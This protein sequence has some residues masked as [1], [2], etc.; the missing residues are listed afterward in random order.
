ME[1]K[2]L[3]QSKQFTW[4]GHEYFLKYNPART[5]WPKRLASTQDALR[6]LSYLP[7]TPVT[8][9]KVVERAI[10][11]IFAF[12]LHATLPPISNMKALAS[13]VRAAVWGVN[14]KRY[15]SW[16]LAC[17]V[18]YRAHMTDVKSALWYSHVMQMARGFCSQSNRDAYQQL[19]DTPARL[20]PRG[21]A[22]I[23]DSILNSLGATLTQDHTFD[24]GPLGQARHSELKKLGHLVRDA[25]R[26]QLFNSVSTKRKNV[27]V[28]DYQVDLVVSS[29]YYRSKVVKFRA[30]LVA[31]LCD[32]VLTQERIA[33]MHE[34]NTTVCTFCGAP[35]EDIE[36]VLWT[37]PRWEVFR[38]LGPDVVRGIRSLPPAA[39]RCSYAL[40]GMTEQLVKAWPK[41]QE[42]ASQIVECHQKLV[43]GDQKVGQPMQ[44][45]RAQIA[46]D[47]LPAIPDAAT[48]ANGVLLSVSHVQELATQSHAWMYSRVQW[49]Q[50]MHW[51]T[52]LK[53]SLQPQAVPR[54]SVIEL[55]VSYIIASGGAR[56]SSGLSEA[57]HG[58]WWTTQLAQF[59]RALRAMQ[60]HV[61]PVPVVPLQDSDAPR[62]DW[63][64]RWHIPPQVACVPGLMVPGHRSVRDYL[65]AWSVMPTPSEATATP[66]AELW[67]RQPIGDHESQ[68][69]HYSMLP[70]QS[71]AWQWPSSVPRIRLRWKSRLPPWAHAFYANQSWVREVKSLQELHPELSRL[72]Q[73]ASVEGTTG[74]GDLSRIAG[75]RTKRSLL[76][77]SLVSHNLTAIDSS[78]HIAFDGG[79]RV[80]CSL[81]EAAAPLSH[82]RIWFTKTCS[83]DRG[84]RRDLV[85]VANRRLNDLISICEEDAATLKAAAALLP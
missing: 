4:L 37:C 12:G 39:R 1:W 74:R 59:M 82:T 34:G 72:V 57:S 49:N 20:R 54:I 61:L 3:A 81:C 52:S 47:D 42:Q 10:A 53:M 66:G 25:L 26:L 6:K 56:F 70:H 23:L 31:L 9:Q 73:I 21:P 58:S 40:S 80:M 48:W 27:C 75:K 15:H 43:C 7:V 44:M 68:R 67:R 33:H 64:R 60:A 38:T 45:Q 19:Q 76:F 69:H 55:Y 18:L 71:L 11:P 8:K 29:R 32:G 24:F 65:S 63:C 22:Q 46:P 36:H 41:Y 78:S 17:S 30:G 16:P 14:K 79:I 77:K 50:L 84:G 62:V 13:S 5:A 85:D 83:G 51:L 28:G 35:K 2:Q